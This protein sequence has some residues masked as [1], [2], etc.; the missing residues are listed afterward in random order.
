MLSRETLEND[1]LSSRLFI[2]FDEISLFPYGCIY[3]DNAVKLWA[4]Y[5][6]L[7]MIN[8]Y[9]H[10]TAC[11]ALSPASQQIIFLAFKPIYNLADVLVVSLK[12]AS[13]RCL[14]RAGNSSLQ[15]LE[16]ISFPTCCMQLWRNSAD[17]ESYGLK[18]YSQ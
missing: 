16:S 15:I 12:L 5:P 9:P 7:S 3:T 10:Q 11:G 6:V 13:Q 18:L 8:L 4:L 2:Q 14:H 1:A 17:F